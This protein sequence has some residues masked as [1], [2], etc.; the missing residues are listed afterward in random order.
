MNISRRIAITIFSIFAPIIL[1]VSTTAS[2]L[3]EAEGAGNI[4]HNGRGSFS[5]GKWSIYIEC[6]EEGVFLRHGVSKP[7]RLFDERIKI[8]NNGRKSYVWAQ[9][10]AQYKL[11]WNPLDL[12][13]ARLE[14]INTSGI[15]IVNTL[16]KVAS[17]PPC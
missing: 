9:K 4:F 17:L 15:K 10:G 6:G 8:N 3:A 12:G 16:L 13:F 1:N 7:L 2:V 14:I 11:S 5:D